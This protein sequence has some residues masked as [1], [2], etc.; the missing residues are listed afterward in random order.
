MFL[1]F[2]WL[3]FRSPLYFLNDKKLWLDLRQDNVIFSSSSDNDPGV[4]LIDKFLKK[5]GASG[6]RED[7]MVSACSIF[8]QILKL[9]M[10]S[11]YQTCQ[12]WKI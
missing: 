11:E 9:Q 1:V 8:Q 2:K 10:R 5:K 3:V 6:I 12:T 4:S 7:D